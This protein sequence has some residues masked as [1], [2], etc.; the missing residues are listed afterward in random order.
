L[1]KYEIAK[2]LTIIAMQN[3]YIIKDTSKALNDKTVD[4]NVLIAE[5]VAIFYNKLVEKLDV[6]EE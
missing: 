2:E 4:K 1:N 6:K 5:Q 3:E